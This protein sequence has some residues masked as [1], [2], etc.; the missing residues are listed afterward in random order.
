MSSTQ[1]QGASG[2]AVLI[3]IINTRTAIPSLCGVP[4]IVNAQQH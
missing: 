2:I 3:D 1:G 4:L